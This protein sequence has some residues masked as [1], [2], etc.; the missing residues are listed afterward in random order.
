MKTVVPSLLT[1]VAGCLIIIDLFPGPIG[2]YF[3][4]PIRQQQSKAGPFTTPIWSTAPHP[5][6]VP[7]L[8]RNFVWLL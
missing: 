2:E 5:L 7:V 8:S 1:N 3:L 4:L 6:C